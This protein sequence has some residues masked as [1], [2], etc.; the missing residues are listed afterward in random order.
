MNLPLAKVEMIAIAA[1]Q[2]EMVYIDHLE[3]R[4]SVPPLWVGFDNDTG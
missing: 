2:E 4:E 1:H 3:S